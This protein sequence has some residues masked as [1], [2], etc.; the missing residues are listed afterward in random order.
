MFYYSQNSKIYFTHVTPMHGGFKGTY[1]FPS[2]C[3]FFTCGLAATF[4]RLATYLRLRCEFPATFLRL[5]CDLLFSYD[6]AA[7]FLSKSQESSRKL[8][9][10]SQESSS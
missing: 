5:S 8:A 6:L 3:F 2:L 1:T 7:T 10:K 4:L 9:A